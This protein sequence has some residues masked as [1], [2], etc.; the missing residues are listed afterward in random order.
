MLSF[1]LT[2]KY[3]RYV[4]VTLF[5]RI[6]Y[7]YTFHLRFYVI[8]LAHLSSLGTPRKR[9]KSSLPTSITLSFGGNR[10]RDQEKNDPVLD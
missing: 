8:P 7:F 3:L 5:L 10:G 9:V 2:K 6:I 1:S 4:N